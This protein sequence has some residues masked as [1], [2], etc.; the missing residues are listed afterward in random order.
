MEHF[1]VFSKR[2]YQDGNEVKA[3]WYR[4]GIMKITDGGGHFLR[5]FIV[6]DQTFYVFPRNQEE[7]PLPTIE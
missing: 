7:E 3:K 6:P 4:V 1:N 5:L 2:E